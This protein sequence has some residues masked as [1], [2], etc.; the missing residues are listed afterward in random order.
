MQRAMRATLD[1]HGATYWS[2]HYV[3]WVHAARRGDILETDLALMQPDDRDRLVRHLDDLE[4]R[5]PMSIPRQDPNFGEEQLRESGQR[6]LDAAM[7]YWE[8]CH[9][10]RSELGG[11]I[12]WL[13]SNDGRLV[14]FTRG[15]YRARLLENVDRL[16]LPVFVF[17]AEPP[18][19]DEE[20]T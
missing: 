3:T 7:A 9:K 12:Q 5:T 2:S 10:F 19:E 13:E 4:K 1:K 14:I 11:A 17:D 16:N 18:P 20:R 15:E 6:L 8:D